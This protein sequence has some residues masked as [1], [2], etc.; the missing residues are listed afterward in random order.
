[1][2]DEGFWSALA[3]RVSQVSG[4][5]FVAREREA[6]GGG[7]IHA[8]FRLGDGQV[9]YFVKLNDALA[10][11]MFAAEA[12]GLA[13]LA[14]A[15]AVRVPRPVCHGVLGARAFLV[16]EWL[17]LAA[18]GPEAGARL[19][20]ALAQLHGQRGAYFGWQR[21][22][23][24]GA[25]PQPNAAAADWVDFFGR[26]R[27]G[28]Q[29]ERA[30]RRL[31]R[32]AEPGARLIE[33]LPRFFAGY[34]PHASLL[35]GDLWGGNWAA[36]GAEPVIFDPAVYYGD[37]EADLAMTELFGGFGAHF[38]AAYRAAWPLDAGYPLR[39]DLYNLY[40]VLNHFNLFGGS[41]GAQAER[42]MRRLL[43]EV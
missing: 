27:L 29:L 31:P 13:A 37:R 21:D 4:R 40:H 5:R 1:M 35:H 16:L 28:F 19:G 9:S 2:A 17:P 15:G 25:T 30:T 14:Q 34:G 39:R 7:C 8:A 41:Y 24:L 18:P 10:A 6:I 38:Y 26:Q 43:A 20:E 36:V 42:M 11:D 23:F 33:A 12:D 3:E 22:N 32:L